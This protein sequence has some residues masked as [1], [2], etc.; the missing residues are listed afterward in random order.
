MTERP[1]EIK[2][3]TNVTELVKRCAAGDPESIREFF[4]LFS[5]DIYNFPLKVF[6]LDQDS[7]SE[8]YLYAYERL[9]N[10]KRLRSFQG[11]SSFKT[12]F[13]SV[14]RNM[15]I[16]WMR[17]VRL[18]PTVTIHKVDAEGREF[19]TIEDEADPA[20]LPEEALFGADELLARFR[21][22]L[23]DLKMD[24]RII[25]KLSY[26]F[27]LNLEPEELEFLA[28]KQGISQVE[29]QRKLM[30]I[31]SLLTKK[32]AGLVE[33]EDRLTNLYQNIQKL[34]IKRIKILENAPKGQRENLNQ[35]DLFTLEK[36]EHS[37]EKK[38]T[39]RDKILEKFDKSK[40]IVRTPYKYI[41]EL[42]GVPEGSLSVQLMRTIDKMK[43]AMS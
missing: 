24:S 5:Q 21:H 22:T 35:D 12:W 4:E 11:K 26:L 39:Q 42:L 41:S 17:T 37:L 18:V 8:F 43:S 23:D 2:E 20:S 14:L 6:Q 34:R 3:N 33:N 15:V 1:P 38:L 27:Y 7:A 31:L 30:D 10:G 32:H 16:D 9:C 40:P 28:E 19:Q 13:Y 29:L 25:F 36:L